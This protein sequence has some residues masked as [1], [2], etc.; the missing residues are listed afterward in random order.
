MFMMNISFVT[1]IC[2]HR[3]TIFIFNKKNSKKNKKTNQPTSTHFL[4][5]V[6]NLTFPISPT[7]SV[8]V[9][10]DRERERER[11]ERERGG[12]G[13]RER[14]ERTVS[15]PK[16][17]YPKIHLSV[18]QTV[19]V[20]IFRFMIGL[21]SLFCLVLLFFFLF[22]FWRMYHQSVMTRNCQRAIF[23]S[24]IFQEQCANSNF[25]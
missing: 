11:G 4:T 19:C 23:L 14:L 3:S 25:Q 13:E 2:N 5:I 7:V 21:F 17:V 1:S 22:F 8:C 10:V 18:L 24:Y 9:C 15:F 6:K 12:G 16:P 20:R